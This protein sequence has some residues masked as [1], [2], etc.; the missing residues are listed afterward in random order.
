[1]YSA[2]GAVAFRYKPIPHANRMMRNRLL[3]NR[4]RSGV[5]TVVFFI[6]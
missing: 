3:Y 2:S 1:L 4:H 5:F 6:N